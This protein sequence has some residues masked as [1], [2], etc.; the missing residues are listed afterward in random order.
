M[1]SEDGAVLGDAV[2]LERGKTASGGDVGLA[3]SARLKLTVFQDSNGDG[4]RGDYDRGVSG[5][6]V[7]LLDGETP[8]DS[9]VT[10]SEGQAALFARS[11]R[12]TVRVTL[13]DGYSLSDGSVQSHIIDQD[14]SFA[15]GEE[16]A[17]TLAV[18][19]VGALGGKVFEDID[20][21]GVMGE[22]EP[23]VAGVTVHIEGNRTGTVRDIT[24]DETGVYLFDFLPCLLYTSRCV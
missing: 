6:E 1:A 21:D 12:Y 24:T 8:L 2:T 3:S 22:D 23:G 20:N 18:A 10:D 7:T 14:V 11:G 5:I 16:E 19:P 17:L 13:P 4:K 9:A 15:T